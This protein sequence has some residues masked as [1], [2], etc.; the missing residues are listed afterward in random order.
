MNV[1]YVC[2]YIAIN[3]LLFIQ[4]N[5]LVLSLLNMPDLSFAL[6]KGPATPQAMM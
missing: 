6:D 2:R 1:L 5:E 3:N 4:H